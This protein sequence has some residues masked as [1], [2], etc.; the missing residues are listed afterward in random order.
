M[1]STGPSATVIAV[2]PVGP[3]PART[4]ASLM[5]GSVRS[6]PRREAV[7]RHEG[8]AGQGQVS[9]AMRNSHFRP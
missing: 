1:A 8:R 6:Q 3:C 5:A 9:A 2:P 7:F 4:V